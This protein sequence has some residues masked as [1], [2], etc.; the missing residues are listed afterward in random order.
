MT[1]KSKLTSHTNLLSYY[2]VVDEI[3]FFVLEIAQSYNKQQF[4]VNKIVNKLTNI[5]EKQQ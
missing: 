4:K 3:N 5:T 1:K 2:N